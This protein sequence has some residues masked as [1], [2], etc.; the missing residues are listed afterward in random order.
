MKERDEDSTVGLLA[1]EIQE[2][3]EKGPNV[4]GSSKGISSGD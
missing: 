4:S 3:K 1:E 2:L